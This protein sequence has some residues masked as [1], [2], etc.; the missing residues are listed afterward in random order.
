MRLIDKT[1]QP[2]GQPM[3]AARLPRGVSTT[4]WTWSLSA[5]VGSRARFVTSSSLLV[6]TIPSRERA[7]DTDLRS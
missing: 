2:F 7:T 4:A 1:R 6:A 5:Q 3:I